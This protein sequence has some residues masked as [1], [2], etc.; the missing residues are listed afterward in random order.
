MP[1]HC[2][3]KGAQRPFSDSSSS[4]CTVWIAL[5]YKRNHP[6]SI[7]SSSGDGVVVAAVVVPP[8]SAIVAAVIVPEAAAVVVAVVVVVVVVGG[9]GEEE[10][11]HLIISLTSLITSNPIKLNKCGM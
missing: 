2:C 1:F 11:V 8:P 9:G 10:R 7:S 5:Q 6:I 3:P 4:S